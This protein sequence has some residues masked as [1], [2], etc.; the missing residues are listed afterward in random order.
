[1]GRVLG[2]SGL[3]RVV[4]DDFDHLSWI[5]SLFKLKDEVFGLDGISLRVKGD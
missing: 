2:F 1:M 5:L 3:G 4:L